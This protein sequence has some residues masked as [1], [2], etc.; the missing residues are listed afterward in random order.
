MAFGRGPDPDS[1]CAGSLHAIEVKGRYSWVQQELTMSE[2]R[3]FTQ[4]VTELSRYASEVRGTL[5]RANSLA[6]LAGVRAKPLASIQRPTWPE[7]L[8][9]NRENL[10]TPKPPHQS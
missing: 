5:R 4:H 9:K 7:I 1:E 2:L 6:A 10:I 3:E 8:K